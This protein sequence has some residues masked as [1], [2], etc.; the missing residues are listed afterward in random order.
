MPEPTAKKKRA[1]TV[2]R[3]Y[4]GVDAS[5]RRKE[6]HRKLI[7]AGLEVFG[8]RGYHLSTVRDVCAQAGLTERYFYESFK[9]L[10]EVFDA[11]YAELRGIVQ[12]RVVAGVLAQGL[13]RPEPLALAECALRAWYAFLHEDARRARIMLVDA[14]SVSESGM[15]GAEAAVNEFKGILRTFIS[16]TYP[17]L[18]KISVDM[19]VVV[20]SLIGATIYTAKTWTQ[21]GFRQSLDDILRH[22]MLMFRGMDAMYTQLQAQHGGA[23][24]EA[25]AA[26]PRA[27]RNGRRATDA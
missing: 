27:S 7:D 16:M 9:T 15:R 6:R 23:L 21:S 19:D 12:Q 8:T 25:K 20:A 26:T 24:A 13:A 3:R 22:N 2:T 14:V 11:V 10:S 17:D 5:E 4:G 18:D 1:A